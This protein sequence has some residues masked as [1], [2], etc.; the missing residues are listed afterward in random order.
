VEAATYLDAEL[1]NLLNGLQLT[2]DGET[3]PLRVLARSATYKPG[4]GGLPTLRIEANFLA[5]LPNGWEGHGA[6]HYADQNYEG[7][8]GWQE[9]VVRGGSGVVVED[10]T[11]PTTEVSSELRS[12]PRDSLSSPLNRREATFALASGDGTAKGASNSRLPESIGINNSGGV[13]DRVTSL[14]SVDRLSPT[15]VAILILTALL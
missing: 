4:Q 2:V 8:V 10:S 6:G 7:R 12:Y 13:P 1:P 15:I 5:D 3:L 9:I 11:A 14:I